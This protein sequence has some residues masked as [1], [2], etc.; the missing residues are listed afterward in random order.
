MKRVKRSPKSQKKPRS[1]APKRFTSTVCSCRIESCPHDD[2]CADAYTRLG[3]CPPALEDSYLVSV[4][5]SSPHTIDT[6]VEV[7]Q[8]LCRMLGVQN[9]DSESTLSRLIEMS[10]HHTMAGLVFELFSFNPQTTDMAK[11]IASLEKINSDAGPKMHSIAQ[12][13]LGICYMMASDEFIDRGPKA[14]ACFNLAMSLGDAMASSCLATCYEHG[15]GVEESLGKAFQ[16]YQTS[17]L[18]GVARSFYTLAHFYE[19]G[20]FIPEDQTM[21]VKYLLMAA[22]RGYSPALMRLS[23][24]FYKGIHCKPDFL[25]GSR[26]LHAAAG[27]GDENGLMSVS[28]FYFSGIGV[29]RNPSVGFDCFKRAAESR[30]NADAMVSYGR[31]YRYG[32]G[33]AKSKEKSIYWYEQAAR[34]GSADGKYQLGKCY[35]L[36]YTKGIPESERKNFALSYYNEALLGGCKEA[37]FSIERLNR[38]Y[39][40]LSLVLPLGDNEFDSKNVSFEVRYKKGLNMEPALHM[41]LQNG[42][43]ESNWKILF[44]FLVKNKINHLS[45]KGNGITYIPQG[46][47]WKNTFLNTIDLSDNNIVNLPNDFA[48]QTKLKVLSVNNTPL[49]DESVNV[50]L[51]VCL[52][53]CALQNII[54][55]GDD[56]P[57]PVNIPL[58][59]S[60]RSRQIRAII[61]VALKRRRT[62][63]DVVDILIGENL[64]DALHASKDPSAKSEVETAIEGLLPLPIFEEVYDHFLPRFPVYKGKQAPLIKSGDI[65]V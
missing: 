43:S 29:H 5:E 30:S 8:S 65:F 47:G 38:G 27:R 26:F 40:P 53:S 33:V 45:L 25:L 24:R 23:D 16:L 50:L 49:S 20:K 59:P 60:L 12:T 21:A 31:C 1:K 44:E 42:L 52:N 17:S 15:F 63:Q 19:T 58:G 57:F 7:N 46:L 35:E 54:I 2:I 9:S 64:V 62:R 18:N 36:G 32:A 34:M 39:I 41:N 55:P 11:T 4:V 13:L 22:N 14:V 10:K 28:R 3:G 6:I 61:K 48:Y 37:A 56:G 51:A